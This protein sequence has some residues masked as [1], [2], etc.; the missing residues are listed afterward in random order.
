VPGGGGSA[1]SPDPSASRMIF[2]LIALTCAKSIFS[3]CLS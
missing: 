3:T 1:P 2:S